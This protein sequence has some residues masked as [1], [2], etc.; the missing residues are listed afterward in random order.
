MAISDLM[1]V[2]EQGANISI[3]NSKDEF[4]YIGDCY[5]IPYRLVDATVTKMN[6]RKVWVE[7]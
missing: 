6:G 1:R 2:W 4:Q 5:N 7:V 3:L